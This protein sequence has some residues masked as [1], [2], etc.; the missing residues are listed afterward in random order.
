MLTDVCRSCG[1]SGTVQVNESYNGGYDYKDVMCTRCRGIGQTPENDPG[2]VKIKSKEWDRE[3]RLRLQAITN[4]FVDWVGKGRP[5][6]TEAE[7]EQIINDMVKKWM[8]D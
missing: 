1:G 6:R 8:N 5:R 3:R 4:E 7:R 2:L